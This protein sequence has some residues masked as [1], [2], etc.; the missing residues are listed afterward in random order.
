MT[1]TSVYVLKNFIVTNHLAKNHKI[2]DLFRHL[3]VGQTE[4][5]NGRIWVGRVKLYIS[6]LQIRRWRT[7]TLFLLMFNAS[8]LFVIMHYA[9]K[10]KPYLVVSKDVDSILKILV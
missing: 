7:F 1:L 6:A 10:S 9:G 8:M 3:Q 5:Q 2:S 4:C